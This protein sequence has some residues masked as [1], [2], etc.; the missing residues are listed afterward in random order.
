VLG[1]GVI[2]DRIESGHEVSE[3]VVGELLA[4]RGVADEVD[5]ADRELRRRI[6]VEL[7]AGE[8]APQRGPQLKAHAVVD[9]ARDAR[10]VE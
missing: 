10:P 6:L 5:E 4:Q 8:L 2:G 7:G 1:D 3:L 9:E